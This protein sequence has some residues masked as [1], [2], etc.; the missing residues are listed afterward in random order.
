M[1]S[2]LALPLL[3][4]SKC[5]FF[6][7]SGGG[8]SDKDKN[9]SQNEVIVVASG[10]FGD[11]R[12]EGVSYASGSLSGVTGKDG[13][14]QYEAGKSIRF[15]IG[16][17][18]LGTVRAGQS[19]VTPQDLVAVGGSGST[20]AINISRLLLSLD[21]QP[22]DSAITIPKSARLSAVRSNAAVSSDIAFLDF[23]DDTSFANNASQL[24]AVLTQDYTFTAVLVDAGTASASRL[25]T[26]SKD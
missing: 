5:A 24:V 17:I 11:P 14:F 16:D 25:K 13:L 2:L 8:S 6:F 21:S 10:Y 15:F 20:A 1:L 19:L 3:V 22:G 12:T 9:D 7:S 18:N 23:S 4:G 26:P